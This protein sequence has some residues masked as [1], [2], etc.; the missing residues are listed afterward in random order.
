MNVAFPKSYETAP[1]VVVSLRRGSY[2][3]RVHVTNETKTG[4]TVVC[5]ALSGSG[6]NT[7]WYSWVAV[8]KIG[9][10]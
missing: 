5:A 1:S 2:N 4:F 10:Y 9:G 3:R 6:Q 7:V 8:G